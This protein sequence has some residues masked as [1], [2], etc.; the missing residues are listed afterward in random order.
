MD[1]GLPNF[2]PVHLVELLGFVLRREMLLSPLIYCYPDWLPPSFLP[3][4][5]PLGHP[6]FHPSCHPSHATD[7]VTIVVYKLFK[8][9]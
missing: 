1:G 6:S 3:T 2:G 7:H 9:M 5:P 4:P 8:S